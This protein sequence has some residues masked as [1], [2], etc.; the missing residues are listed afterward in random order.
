[1]TTKGLASLI[2]KKTGYPVS[3]IRHIL[4]AQTDIMRAQLIQQGEVVFS[5]LFRLTS[6]LRTV[7]VIDKKKVRVKVR[8]IL[9]QVKPVK[10]FRQELSR[11]TNTQF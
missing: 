9:L 3:V 1:M 6:V 11:W 4:D 8:R 7:E 2:A 5:G 10:S